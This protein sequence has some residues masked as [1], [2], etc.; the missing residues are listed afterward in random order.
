VA[1]ILAVVDVVESKAA[2]REAVASIPWKCGALGRRSPTA[3]YRLYASAGS[4]VCPLPYTQV[5]RIFHHTKLYE[6]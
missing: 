6:L 5:Q 3:K 4:G 1:R 2:R